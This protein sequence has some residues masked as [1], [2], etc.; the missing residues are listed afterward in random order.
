MMKISGMYVYQQGQ[1]YAI[2]TPQG[3]QVALVYMGADGQIA[4]D[5]ATLAPICK[6]LAKRWGV[7]ISKAEG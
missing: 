3:I 4:F 7:C 5:V 6:A 2:Y 1:S